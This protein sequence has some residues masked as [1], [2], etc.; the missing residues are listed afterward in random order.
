M[1]LKKNTVL[2]KFENKFINSLWPFTIAINITIGIAMSRDFF[3][4]FVFF[5]LR[6][7]HPELT[8]VANP[9]FLA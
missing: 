3:C 2:N 4:S 9:P 6:K 5:L 1:H 8:S 7:I